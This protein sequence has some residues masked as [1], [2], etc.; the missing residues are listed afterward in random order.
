M[1]IWMPLAAVSAWLLSAAAIAQPAATIGQVYPIAERD[2]L[3]EISA[4]A[5]EVNWREAMTKPR[6]EW[7]AYRFAEVPAAT[8]AA[9]REHR[10][11][12][13]VE[14]P[15]HSA[16]GTLIYPAGFE[17]NPLDY[18]TLPRR[19]VVIR[20]EHALWAKTQLNAT[21]LVLLAGADTERAGRTLDR[22]VFILDARTKARLGVRAAP[23]VIEQHG[24]AL[25][26]TEHIVEPDDAP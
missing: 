20:P 13:I 7:S 22:P 25:V 11:I 24:T 3:E 19:V 18:L 10:P 2:A 12:H 4:R 5:A 15:V 14:Y 6:S 23:S 21:D 16:D 17:F 8:Q 9:R 1:S 26:I